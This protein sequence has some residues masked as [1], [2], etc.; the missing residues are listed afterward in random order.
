LN[1]GQ[2]ASSSGPRYEQ[3]KSVFSTKSQSADLDRAEM[4]EKLASA[5]SDA[6]A[7]QMHLAMAAEYRRRAAADGWTNDPTAE[8][9]I[10]PIPHR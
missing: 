10:E 6:L 7:R 2:T 5:T 9:V 8:L 1:A 3:E 4:H